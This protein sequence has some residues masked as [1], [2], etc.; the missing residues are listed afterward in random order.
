MVAVHLTLVPTSPTPSEPPSFLRGHLG[1]TPASVTG[2]C[3]VT[4]GATAPAAPHVD[5]PSGIGDG[6]VLE[7]AL[8]GVARTGWFDSTLRSSSA[9]RQV[10]NPLHG[11]V[12][13]ERK[14]I[15]E[16]LVVRAADSLSFRVADAPA[17]VAAGTAVSPAGPTAPPTR[18]SS[19]APPLGSPSATVRPPLSPRASPLSS[20]GRYVLCTGE[21]RIP[22]RFTLP[23]VL[24]PSFVSPNGK[25]TYTLSAKL[26]YQ[27]IRTGRKATKKV[28]ETLIIRR[29]YLEH[30]VPP[31]PSPGLEDPPPPGLF[32]GLPLSRTTTVEFQSWDDCQEPATISSSDSPVAR[33]NTAK[34]DVMVPNRSFGPDDPIIAHIHIKKL[35]EGHAVHHVELTVHAVVSVRARGEVKTTRH[36]IMRHRDL[37]VHSGWFWNRQINIAPRR[38]PTGSSTNSVRS[39]RPRAG[40][41]PTISPPLPSAAAPPYVAQALPGDHDRPP[42]V[43]EE[44]A[45]RAPTDTLRT[46]PVQTC[47]SGVD[48]LSAHP[49][50]VPSE[51][52]IR[53]GQSPGS[54][55]NTTSANVVLESGPLP[56]EPLLNGLGLVMRDSE[57]LTPP[58]VSD[59]DVQR[60]QPSGQTIGARTS[61]RRAGRFASVSPSRSRSPASSWLVPAEPPAIVIHPPGS[62]ESDQ[63][64]GTNPPATSVGSSVNRSWSS[65]PLRRRAAPAVAAREASRIAERSGLP[66][67]GATLPGVPD[68]VGNLSQGDESVSEAA[69]TRLP[70]PP[71]RPASHSS[72][73]GRVL[74]FERLG[75]IRQRSLPPSHPPRPNPSAD[76]PMSPATDDG[77]RDP[78][79]ESIGSSEQP[80][81]HWNQQERHAAELRTL[82]HPIYS[83]VSPLISV[84]HVLRVEVATYRPLFP[85]AVALGRAA[86]AAAENE[87]E[88]PADQVEQ[89]PPLADDGGAVATGEE[90]G[91]FARWLR[92]LAPAGS[93]SRSRGL[94]GGGARRAS[95]FGGRR[96]AGAGDA[97]V[98]GRGRGRTPPPPAAAGAV[99]GGG[100]ISAS[101]RLPLL[102]RL[103]FAGPVTRSS[104]ETPVVLHAAGDRETRFLHGYIHGPSE[105]DVVGSGGGSGQPA[106]SLAAVDGGASVAAPDDEAGRGRP[107]VSG[108]L[109]AANLVAK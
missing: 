99:A 34:Y 28:S 54:V 32:P 89:A 101:R 35:P 105:T 3:C 30:I 94:A 92:E 70:S 13:E 42:T 102:T 74:L 75:Q 53:D 80:S 37:P 20:P 103:A 56:H 67:A 93:R 7:I 17:N 4:V 71:S 39:Q 60:L 2:I 50:S 96:G 14:V 98:P 69:A 64:H 83:F 29:Y 19:P 97:A 33:Q 36:V 90:R 61:G 43:T 62:A 108:A 41:F 91:R 46:A 104:V 12:G 73:R 23:N 65:P 63:I 25:I 88:G 107:A 66:P 86:A 1:A 84:R 55:V 45:E 44:V 78:E 87:N 77:G 15:D 18:A 51:S 95:A 22:F 31:A 11:S 40:P 59:T 6:A 52:T 16:R 21:H 57:P 8:V 9:L 68:R 85:A 72:R 82:S 81:L 79:T 26:R 24:P 5:Q 10:A 109:V 49:P 100:G 106:A 76:D 58:G 38:L 47:D 48:V 27:D